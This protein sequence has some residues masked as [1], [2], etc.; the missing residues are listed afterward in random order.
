MHDFFPDAEVLTGASAH[1]RN[2]YGIHLYHSWGAPFAELAALFSRYAKEHEVPIYC[3]E[4]AIPYHGSY[5]H[6][7]LWGT[8]RNKPEYYY[9]Q[10]NGARILGPSAYREKTI[11]TTFAWD[12]WA[13]S[14]LAST[15]GKDGINKEREYCFLS[16]LYAKVL[17]ASIERTIFFWRYDGLD[18]LA[19]FEYFLGRFLTAGNACFGATPLPDDLTQPGIKPDVLWGSHVMPLFS[20]NSDKLD[21]RPNIVSVPF[22]DAMDKVTCRI[23]SAGEDIYTDDHAFWGGEELQRAIGVINMSGKALQYTAK[24]LLLD[25]SGSVVASTDFAVAVP[26]YENAN[27][28]FK[29][30]LPQVGNRREY[31][32]RVILTPRSEGETLCAAQQIQIFPSALSASVRAITLFGGTQEF[33]GALTSLGY[34]VRKVAL[35]DEPQSIDASRVLLIAPGALQ[36]VAVAPDFS[37]WAEQYGI[38]TLIMEQYANASRELIKI[39]TRQAFIN[40]PHHPVLSGFEDV[41][42]SE[43]RGGYSL[44]P[45]Y[46]I[47]E[48]GH[49][50]SSAKW[51]D[52]GN[53]GMVAGKIPACLRHDV[54]RV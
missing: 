7:N 45:S 31:M 54:L 51:T 38:R 53:R 18:G 47:A 21:W 15:R 42:F 17:D 11:T 10:E 48:P 16:E 27:M 13:N 8:I 26:V 20:P 39:R 23:I 3:G 9:W 33:A 46:G 2:A 37:V 5:A 34:D 35:L 12:G 24:A 40:A 1:V 43:W 49:P 19:P 22:K 28:P 36:N 32:L 50:W 52:W 6:L 14:L 4:Y 44:I 30:T 41:D 29:L 25:D